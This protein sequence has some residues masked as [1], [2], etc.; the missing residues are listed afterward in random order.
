MFDDWHGT[1]RN[2]PDIS[3]QG[4]LDEIINGR[5]ITEEEFEEIYSYLV[6]MGRESRPS[7]CRFGDQ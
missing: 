3:Y 7:G 1:A 2:N 6:S 5:E 4:L